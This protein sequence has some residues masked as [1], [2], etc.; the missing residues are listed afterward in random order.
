MYKIDP[1]K[2]DMMIKSK[3]MDFMN[4]WNGEK[5]QDHTETINRW[6]GIWEINERFEYD[7]MDEIK[8]HHLDMR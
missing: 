4:E 5:V 1:H 7:I 3:A 8:G 2:T 6:N